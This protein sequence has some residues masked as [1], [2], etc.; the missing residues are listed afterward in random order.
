MTKL[1]VLFNVLSVLNPRIIFPKVKHLGINSISFFGSLGYKKLPNHFELASKEFTDININVI[2]KPS[3]LNLTK[4]QEHLKKV[5]P[6]TISDLAELGINNYIWMIECNLFGQAFNPLMGK[7]VNANKLTEHFKLFYQI[8]HDNNPNANV[9]IVIYPHRLINLD[10]GLRGWKDWWVKKGEKLKFD[11][12]AVDAHIGTWIPAPTKHIVYSHLI[13]TIDFLQKR[14]YPPLYI[15]VG[16]PTVG[17]KPLLGWFGWGREKDQLNMLKV[18]YAA[19][20]NMKVPFMQ[21]C[22]FIDPDPK[23]QIYETFFGDEGKLPKFLA[24]SVLEE[25]HWGLLRRD[26]SKK[27]ACDWIRKITKMNNG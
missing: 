19:I 7:Y 12:V 17:H 3:F 14:G 20:K 9:I 24:F 25:A 18:C 11:T 6:R 16:Y 8:A 21:I 1:R 27:L 22:E 10:C 5:G 23:G 2:H 15:E 13:N 4:W 26:G